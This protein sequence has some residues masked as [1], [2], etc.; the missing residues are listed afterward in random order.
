MFC[1]TRK[2]QQIPIGLKDTG[3]K[4]KRWASLLAGWGHCIF[5]VDFYDYIIS[6]LRSTLSIV[7]ASVRCLAAAEEGI[8]FLTLIFLLV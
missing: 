1:G 5:N 6:A 2:G 7:D 3:E 8:A 4:E